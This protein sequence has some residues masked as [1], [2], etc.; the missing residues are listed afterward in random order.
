MGDCNIE[1][2]VTPRVIPKMW[3]SAQGGKGQTWKWRSISFHG[4][5]KKTHYQVQ[6]PQLSPRERCMLLNVNRVNLCLTRRCTTSQATYATVHNSFSRNL[7]YRKPRAPETQVDRYYFQILSNLEVIITGGKSAHVWTVGST[8]SV[9]GWKFFWAMVYNARIKASSQGSDGMSHQPS[10]RQE[11]W[12]R[13]WQPTPVFL[14]GEFHGRACWNT[15][16]GV[17]KSRTRLTFLPT[18]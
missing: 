7:Q 5:V 6:G 4:T 15:V 3:G 2:K 14:P 8:D 9:E 1:E 18:W 17:A 11:A 12:R 10:L 16:H 13:K